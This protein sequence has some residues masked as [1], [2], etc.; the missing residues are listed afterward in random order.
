VTDGE[1]SHGAESLNFQPNFIKISLNL[2]KFDQNCKIQIKK[3]P[4]LTGEFCNPEPTLEVPTLAPPLDRSGPTNRLEEQK[5]SSPRLPPVFSSSPIRRPRERRKRRERGGGGERAGGE[6]S[7]PLHRYF[8]GLGL[9]LVSTSPSST[10]ASL[11]PFSPS[12]PVH[13][14]RYAVS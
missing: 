3:Q 5:A 11:L 4:N 12:S 10:Y 13:A 9:P 7:P 8:C 1:N 14:Q 6:P 2:I